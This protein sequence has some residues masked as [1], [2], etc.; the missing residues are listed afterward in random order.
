MKA[1]KMQ[2]RLTA[3]KEM[4]AAGGKEH[5]CIRMSKRARSF[6]EVGNPSG[7]LEVKANGKSLSL[8]IHQAYKRDMSAL[9]GK[10]KRKSITEDQAQKTG[11]VTTKTLESLVGKRRHKLE[12][13]CW[14]TEGLGPLMLGAD[15][16]FAILD[17]ATK[18]FVYAG[19][20]NRLPH[21]GSIGH[22]GPLV[23]VRPE[24]STEVEKVVNNIK[25]C[26]KRGEGPVGDYAWCGGAVYRNP[27][28]PE[29]RVPYIGGHVHIGDPAALPKDIRTAVH[30]RIIQVLDEAVSLP[31]CRID[32]P[33]PHVRRN[34]P[35]RHGKTYGRYGDYRNQENRFE[36]RVPSGIWLIHPKLARSILGTA[37][38]VSEHCYQIIGDNK[39]DKS[40]INAPGNQKGF[41]KTWGISDTREVERLINAADPDRIED[42]LIA[43][44]V[45]KLKKM[46]TYETYKAEVDEFIDLVSMSEQDRSKLTLDVKE[47][48]LGSGKLFSA[49]A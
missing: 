42:T 15:P 16:E 21:L 17:P 23:E 19:R 6:F 12:D 33:D 35:D 20:T 38:A 46:E 41:L 10:L 9:A 32:C 29:D 44:V 40:F 24:P 22:D 47:N 27:D 8:E 11:F 2:V 49:Q 30:R 7:R 28:Y 4:D 37:K 31:L 14:L 36:W 39:F 34:K 3:S 5:N 45:G 43:D 26:L 1:P 13:I 18:R 25:K 48:W